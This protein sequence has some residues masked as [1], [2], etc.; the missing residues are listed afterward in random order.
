MSWRLKLATPTLKRS[1]LE[2][3]AQGS[4]ECVN[5]FFCFVFNWL[6]DWKKKT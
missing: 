2:V 5:S 3:T 6:L 1:A 4:A